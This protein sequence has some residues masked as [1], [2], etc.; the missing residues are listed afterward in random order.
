[1][2]AKPISDKVAILRHKAFAHRS[3]HI[4]YND[5]FQ[6]A[7]VRPDQLRE[8]TDIAL[9]ITNQLLLAQG[10]QEQSFSLLP[11]EAAE[12]MMQALGK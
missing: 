10:L 12:A 2:N 4:S 5:A 6:M 9:A 8:L 7:A 3:A 11:R 1:M